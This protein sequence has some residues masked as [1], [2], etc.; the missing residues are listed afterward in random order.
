MNCEFCQSPVHIW[1]DCPK[2]PKGWRPARLAKSNQ[3]RP[4]EPLRHIEAGAV[5][6]PDAQSTAARKDVQDRSS[7]HPYSGKGS[8]RRK[9]SDKVVVAAWQDERNKQL[10]AGTQALPVDTNSA[11]AEIEPDIR[12][13]PSAPDTGVSV[14]H[15]TSRGPGDENGASKFD[16]KSWM[17]EYMRGYMR[18]RRAKNV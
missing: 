8:L 6:E 17:R 11:Q 5:A 16:K 12:A 9:P 18:K 7:G 14:E 13:R 10:P 4:S 2:K 15:A 3:A 1:F